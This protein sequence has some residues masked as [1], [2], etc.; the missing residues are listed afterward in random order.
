MIK[1]RL[2]GILTQCVACKEV[3]DMILESIKV[4]M[5]D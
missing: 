1:Y 4:N 5:V 3:G 2:I